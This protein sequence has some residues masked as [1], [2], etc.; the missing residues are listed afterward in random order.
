MSEIKYCVLCKR[1][2]PAAKNFSWPLFLFLCFTGVGPFIYLLWYFIKSRN[3]CPICKG[4]ALTPVRKE[5]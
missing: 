1:N 5:Y 2:V 4:D 3:M